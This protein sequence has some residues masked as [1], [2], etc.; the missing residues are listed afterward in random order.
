MTSTLQKTSL[1]GKFVLSVL[2]TRSIRQ[3]H[4]DMVAQKRKSTVPASAGA[5]RAKAATEYA[6]ATEPR[7]PE[8]TPLST[9]LKALQDHHQR[10]SPPVGDVVHWFRSD[11]RL[12][13]NRALFAAS[14]RAKETGKGLIAFYVVSPQVQSVES[15]S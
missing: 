12:G 2:S 3:F 10:I 14:Q 1:Y 15:Q 13:D 6:A 9:L 4:S 8:E 11:L 5:K 7:I